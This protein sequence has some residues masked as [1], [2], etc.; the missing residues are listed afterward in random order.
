MK[1]LWNACVYINYHLT[2]Y[3]SPSNTIITRA[4]NEYSSLDRRVDLC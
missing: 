3:V 1:N 4:V 2:G